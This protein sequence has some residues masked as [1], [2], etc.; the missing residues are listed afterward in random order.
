ML[1]QGQYRIYDF[2]QRININYLDWQQMPDGWEHSLL[3]I[4]TPE[5][6]EELRKEQR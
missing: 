2:Y 1:Q 3:N 4:N 6:L 5:Q